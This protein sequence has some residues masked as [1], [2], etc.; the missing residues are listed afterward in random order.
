MQERLARRRCGPE[1]AE[2]QARRQLERRNGP[3]AAGAGS[4]RGW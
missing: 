1:R 3:V 2:Q 4:D